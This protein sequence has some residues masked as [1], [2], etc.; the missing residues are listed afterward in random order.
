MKKFIKPLLIV[1]I[2]A[3]A[4]A[5]QAVQKDITV[6]A[7]VEESINIL[8]A[9]G[10]ALP[11]DIKMEYKPSK[12]LEAYSLDTK[13]WSN[14]ATSDV[15][16]QL[17]SPASLTNGTKKVPLTVSLNNQELSISKETLSAGVL[18]PSKQIDQ[19]S[20]ILPLKISQTTQGVLDSGKYSGTV[21]LMVSQATTAPGN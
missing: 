21:T 18:F 2:M 7:E 19:G 16:V 11:S 9:D 1:S 15:S 13:I 5:T 17:F 12:G 4:F 20:V 3:T 10:S 8:Q 6:N 14:N